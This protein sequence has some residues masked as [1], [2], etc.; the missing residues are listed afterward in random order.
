MYGRVFCNLA[1]TFSLQTTIFHEALFISISID[2]N[3]STGK[4]ALRAN[5]FQKL[6]AAQSNRICGGNLNIISLFSFVIRPLWTSPNSD[7]LVKQA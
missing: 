4:L 1:V 3:E 7:D 5:T 6:A 2:K